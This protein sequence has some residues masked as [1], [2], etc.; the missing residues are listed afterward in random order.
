MTEL[1]YTQDG[2]SLVVTYTERNADADDLLGTVESY[3]S[4]WPM[5]GDEHEYHVGGSINEYH[6]VFGVD[7]EHVTIDIDLRGHDYDA[8]DIIDVTDDI[9]AIFEDTD[10]YYHAILGDV[11]PAIRDAF[12]N[13]DLDET[14]YD[15][16]FIGG[17]L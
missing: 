1:E 17:R 2:D 7:D 12:Y 10:S 4:T 8:E 3:D 6:A 16:S 5:H 11:D 15:N 9:E 14:D 13:N